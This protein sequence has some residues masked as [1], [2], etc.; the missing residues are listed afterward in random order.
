MG[1]MVRW[2]SAS[3]AVLS[4]VLGICFVLVAAATVLHLV[5]PSD[6]ASHY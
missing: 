5:R 3:A 6:Y 4:A 2:R 1:K